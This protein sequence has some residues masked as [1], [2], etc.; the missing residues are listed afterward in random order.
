VVPVA[1]PSSLLDAATQAVAGGGAKPYLGFVYQ[2]A[3]YLLVDGAGNG[4]GAGDVLVKLT[5]V[6]L[7]NVSYTDGNLTTV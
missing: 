4:L 5:G 6:N 2:A 7:A 1:A 3:T